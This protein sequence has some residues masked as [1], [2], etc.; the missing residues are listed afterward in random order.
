MRSAL[1]NS[2]LLER[3]IESAVEGLGSHFLKLIRNMSP[4]NIDLTVN[5]ILTMKAEYN[6]SDYHKKNLILA[7]SKLSTFHRNKPF[8]EFSRADVLI[9][10]DSFRKTEAADPLH[11]WIGTYNLSTEY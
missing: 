4:E 9:F 2:P 8:K 5:F 11:K 3:R 10:L 7:I 6:I 1:V